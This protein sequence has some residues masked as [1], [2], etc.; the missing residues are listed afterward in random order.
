MCRLNDAYL[1]RSADTK[2]YLNRS[3]EKE[4]KNTRMYTKRTIFR[5]SQFKKHQLHTDNSNHEVKSLQNTLT[6]ETRK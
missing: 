4:K 6:R 5:K 2:A 1:N 3:A